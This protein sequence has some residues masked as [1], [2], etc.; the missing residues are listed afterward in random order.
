[1]W[2]DIRIPNPT[3]RVTIDVPPKLTSGKGMPTT[4]TIPVTMAVFTKT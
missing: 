1:V 2:I 3:I 4:G